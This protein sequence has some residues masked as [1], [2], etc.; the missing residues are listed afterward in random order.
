[1]KN[2]AQLNM[3]FAWIFAIIVGAFIIFLVVFGISKFV[4]LQKTQQSAET[5]K[6]ID[7]LLNPLETG[8]ETSQMV[9]ISAPLETR[10][11][12]QCSEPIGSEVFGKQRIRTFQKSLDNRWTETS[13]DV[14]SRNKYIFTENSIEGKNFIAFSKPFE[15]PSERESDFPFKV[16]DLVYLISEEDNYC[17]IGAPEEIEE[18]L[19]SLQNNSNIKNFYFNNCPDESKKVCFNSGNDCYAEVSYNSGTVEK[20]SEIVHFETDALMYA[21]IFSETDEYECQLKRIMSRAEQLVKIY[22]EKSNVEKSVGCSGELEAELIIFGSLLNSYENSEELYFI[23][24]QA[25][26]L[27]AENGREGDCKLW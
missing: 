25:E 18:E 7:I 11:F 26:K 16:T 23:A 24:N 5:S 3:S 2:K 12:A 4:N 6:E 21:G 1:M 15:F 13:I 27:N 17:F 22:I 9:L 8:F 14:S 10:I 19:G 20:N